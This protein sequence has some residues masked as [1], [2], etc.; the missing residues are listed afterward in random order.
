MD[1]DIATFVSSSVESAFDR[2]SVNVN[3]INETTQKK[4]A[5]DAVIYEVL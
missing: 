2:I 3:A 1:F 4:T 5:T